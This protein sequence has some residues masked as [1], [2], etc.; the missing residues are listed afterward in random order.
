MISRKTGWVWRCTTLAVFIGLVSVACSE[1]QP[2][3]DEVVI[4]TSTTI[5][6]S[7]LEPVIPEDA[8][9]ICLMEG[10]DP[11]HGEPLPSAVARLGDADFLFSLPEGAEAWV[12][13]YQSRLSQNAR[14]VRAGDLIELPASPY[15]GIADEHF[16][17]YPE[18][19]MDYMDQAAALLETNVDS[20][21]G[22]VTQRWRLSA[23]QAAERRAQIE[24]LQGG[25]LLH[26]PSLFGLFRTLD[27]DIVLV[28]QPHG[29]MSEPSLAELSR[30]ES[31]AADGNVIGFV[32]DAFE[33][34]GATQLATTLK[35]NVLTLRSQPDPG[36]DLVVWWSEQADHVLTYLEHHVESNRDR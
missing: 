17:L 22:S 19:A 23:Q 4:A 12:D 32:E 31:L 27:L 36:E 10:G 13:T 7:L 18:A 29:E 34:S 26:H 24:G 2:S 15:P 6:S 9:L 30:A 16:W 14:L 28:L 8:Q 21:P 11:H 33:G 5:L 20:S 3:E 35:M 25:F 1:T